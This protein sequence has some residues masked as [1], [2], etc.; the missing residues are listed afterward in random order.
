MKQNI[1]V[2]LLAIEATICVILSFIQISFANIFSSVMAF[3]FDQFGLGLRTLSLSSTVGNIAAVVFYIAFCSLPFVALF[4]IWK[5]RKLNAEDSLLGL[6]GVVLFVV[7]YLMINPYLIEM[8]SAS[9]A[10]QTF[11]KSMLGSMVY[12][13]LC[14]YFVLR[15]LRIFLLATRQNWNTIWL[16]CS[17]YFL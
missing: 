9:A 13:V 14:G 16:S 10:A 11:G 4:A 12:S 1:L 2:W 6:L 7:L 5:K 8:F 15:V 17:I 3:P